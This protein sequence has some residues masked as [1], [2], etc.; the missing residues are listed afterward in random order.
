MMSIRSCFG[1]GRKT[2]SEQILICLEPGNFERSKRFSFCKLCFIAS[3]NMIE[4]DLTK[5]SMP[6]GHFFGLYTIQL[7]R[8]GAKKFKVGWGGGVWGLDLL[9]LFHLKTNFCKTY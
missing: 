5:C 6:S 4:S 3:I 1:D 9:P 7:N 2:T 8:C